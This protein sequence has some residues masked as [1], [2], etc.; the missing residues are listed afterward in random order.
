MDPADPPGAVTPPKRTPCPCA[1]GPRSTSPPSSATCASSARRFPPHIRYVAVV[2]ADAYGH[3]L[4]QVAGQADARGRRPLRRGQHHRGRA[5]AR[6]RA[7]AGRSSCSAP[8]CPTRTGSSPST[9]SPSPFRRRTRCSRLDAAGRAAGRPIPVH[10]KID[11]GMGRLGVWH[12]EA[13][14]AGAERY[15]ASAHLRLAGVFTH[16]AS[17][18]DDPDVHRGAAPPVPRRARRL[19]PG[20]DLR[21]GRA[22]RPRGQQR[23]AR[24]DAR[25]RA[26]STPSGSGSCSSA[27]SRTRARSCRR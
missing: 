19:R 3:G 22:S 12:E 11:T 17:P 25:P 15:P 13:P 6:A 7:R 1:A 24:D 8:S 21:A 23:G 4:Q 26:R 5:A 27:S 16:F 14:R 10:L 9:T 18:D 2:K 20:R